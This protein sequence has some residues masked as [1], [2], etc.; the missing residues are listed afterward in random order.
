MMKRKGK[1]RKKGP[2]GKRAVDS[3]LVSFARAT[4][5]GTT[6]VKSDTRS[7]PQN[8]NIVQNPPPNWLT[9]TYWTKAMY[10]ATY[11]TSTS[12]INEQNQSFLAS[13]FTLPSGIFSTFDQFCIYEITVTITLA[14]NA[15]SYTTP[16]QVVTA[17]DYDNVASLGAYSEM[18]AYGTCQ[19]SMITIENSLVRS[20]RPCVAPV[21]FG[22]TL[23]SATGISRSWVDSAASSTVQH[24]GFRL[25]MKP[26]ASSVPVEVLFTGLFGFR[27]TF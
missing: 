19:Q 11:T 8:F 9:M 13:S 24:Y 15:T 5:S 23:S 10:D 26:T 25:I 4:G 20:L 1:S 6:V 7:K 18:Y 21:L 14:S 12:V 3:Q 16:V 17:I 22:G 2:G 27:N